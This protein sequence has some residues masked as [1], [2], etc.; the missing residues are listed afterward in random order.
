ETPRCERTSGQNFVLIMPILTMFS[1]IIRLIIVCCRSYQLAEI[2][3]LLISIVVSILAIYGTEDVHLI[4]PFVSCFFVGV[5][6]VLPVTLVQMIQ[7]AIEKSAPGWNYVVISLINTF[8][9]VIGLFFFKLI[10]NFYQE[11]FRKKFS[12]S[13]NSTTAK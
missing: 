9:F 2:L 6:L 7:Q 8:F 3:T 5:F 10:Y 13:N 11:L 1:G 12:P 4:F